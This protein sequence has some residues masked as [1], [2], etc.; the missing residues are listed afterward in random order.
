MTKTRAE[1]IADALLKYADG[2]LAEAI[3]EHIG[4]PDQALFDRYIAGLASEIDQAITGVE[5][6]T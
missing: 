4:H 6:A 1:I 3:D 2:N 5:Q